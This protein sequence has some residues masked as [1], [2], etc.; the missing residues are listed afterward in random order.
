[1][2][3][4]N[5]LVTFC[6]IFILLFSCS[7]YAQQIRLLEK[8][9]Y[10]IKKGEVGDFKAIADSFDLRK[11]EKVAVL[12]GSTVNRDENNL[13]T[14]YNAFW[15]NANG[16]GGNA[17]LVDKVEKSDNAITVKI[18]V[19]YLTKSASDENEM[20]FPVNKIYIFGDLDLERGGTKLIRANLAHIKLPPLQ[21]I[22]LQNEIGEEIVVNYGVQSEEGVTVVGMEN[23]KPV[24]LGVNRLRAG[25][26]KKEKNTRI[27]SWKLCVIEKNIAHFLTKILSVAEITED[28]K[29]N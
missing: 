15:R 9:Y 25:T 11:C 18:S 20:L 19:Y 8:N 4:R 23:G 13:N 14:L 21:Q 27:P 3:K 22:I 12:T 1:M 16:L 10:F 26:G 2:T 5:Y 17:F 29:L 24:Y 28:Y 7:G 6:V